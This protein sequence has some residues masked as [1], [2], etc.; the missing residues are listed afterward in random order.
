MDN[1]SLPPAPPASRAPSGFLLGA[2]VAFGL[3]SVLGLV[4][5]VLGFSWIQQQRNEVRKGWN[6][7]PVVVAAVDISEGTV[8][9]MEMISQRSYPEQFV[10]SSIIKPD[11]AS[12]II[13]QKVLVAMQAG[14][15]LLWSQFETTRAAQRLSDKL[16][17]AM[18]II[19]IK[20]NPENAA[21]GWIRP[22]DHIDVVAVFIAPDTK[23]LTAM[24]LLEN[25]TV[26]AAGLITANTNP[27]LVPEA[28][29]GYSQVSVAVSPEDAERVALMQQLGTLTLTL[30]SPAAPS[31]RP[32]SAKLT[33]KAVITR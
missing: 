3:F 19:S 9:T 1:P 30:R 2:V 10:T 31:T 14:D 15:A 32:K 23:E 5:A 22:N 7:V 12:Y 6:L 11:S 18:R 26:L 28:E 20:A 4:G 13:N 24:T 27:N 17:D 21:G 16:D 29:R 25:V 8:V 33:A